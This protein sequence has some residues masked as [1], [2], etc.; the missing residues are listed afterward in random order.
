MPSG[1]V[2]ENCEECC[3]AVISCF[4]SEDERVKGEGINAL[5]IFIANERL[6]PCLHKHTEFLVESLVDAAK[7]N[8]VPLVRA[9]ALQVLFSVSS[10]P[11][12]LTVPVRLRVLKGLRG[13][14]DDNKRAV[15]QAAV[16]V[17]NRWHVLEGDL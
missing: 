8:E 2:S 4:A 11:T 17:I 3:D 10:F 6:M 1:V 12:G 14:L 13:V 5:G 15:R 16:K 9:R 7:S